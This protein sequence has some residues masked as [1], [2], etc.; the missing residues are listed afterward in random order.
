MS[1][2]VKKVTKAVTS[3]VSKSVS[4]ASKAV[5]NVIKNPLPVIETVALT[6]ITG[7]PS[8][9]AAVVSAANG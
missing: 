2:A 8:L 9:S 7:N 5:S 1:K 3:V 6:A 4:S